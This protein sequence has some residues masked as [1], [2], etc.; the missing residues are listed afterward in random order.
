MT[1]Q[2]RLKNA[3]QAADEGRYEDAL[4]E[5]IWF[6]D[7][8]LEH[9]PA[10]YGVRLSFALEYWMDLAKVYPEARRALEQTRD[11]NSARLMR[12]D[13]NRALF[14]D[15]ACINKKLRCEH[16]TS[17]VFAKLTSDFPELAKECAS[18]ALPALVAAGNCAL[19][20]QYVPNPAETLQ[21][22]SATLNEDVDHLATKPPS[23]AP[24][25]D[26]YVYIYAERVSVLI[27]ILRGTGESEEAERIERS[28]LEL[29]RSRS[30]REAVRIAL[31]VAQPE[32]ID[33]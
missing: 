31:E 15:L 22:F 10:L 33:V 21:R 14:H 20:R 7:H 4:G 1:P 24:M 27:A 23:P 32:T 16:S 12:G 6:H 28:A 9:E 18:L 29:I 11:D 2:E 30:V 13:G 3:K 25:L 19:A 17:D 5:Y 8:A 26:A